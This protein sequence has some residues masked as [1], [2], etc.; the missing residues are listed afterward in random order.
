M[1]QKK[2]FRFGI[3]CRKT[4]FLRSWVLI[5]T[6]VRV[7]DVVAGWRNIIELQ[8][9]YL[10]TGCQ[11]LEMYSDRFQTTLHP[12]LMLQM[13]TLIMVLSK[14]KI[15]RIPI[16]V[17]WISFFKYPRLSLFRVKRIEVS[18]CVLITDFASRSLRFKLV[19]NWDGKI[20]I[21]AMNTRWSH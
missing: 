19:P 1:F 11:A 9:P 7:F 12:L 3:F 15:F 16:V 13:A 6:F 20:Q 8:S 21:W 10:V 17:S 2:Y 14:R 5:G 4:K 18:A